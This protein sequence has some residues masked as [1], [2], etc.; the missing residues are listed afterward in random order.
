M[1][2]DHFSYHFWILQ[3][4]LLVVLCELICVPLGNM[5]HILRAHWIGFDT[6]GKYVYTYMKSWYICICIFLYIIFLYTHACVKSKGLFWCK[7]V[8]YRMTW[9]FKNNMRETFKV[10]EFLFLLKQTTNKHTSKRQL[11]I[12][13]YGT[14]DCMIFL[15]KEKIAR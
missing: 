5:G 12:R 11:P 3:P 6:I 9:M 8:L 15:L 7:K 13:G 2:P 14:K 10:F 1:V 4:Y